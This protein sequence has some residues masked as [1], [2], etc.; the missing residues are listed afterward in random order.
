[1]CLRARAIW[2]GGEEVQRRCVCVYGVSGSFRLL[3]LERW[4]I[5]GVRRRAT[6]N[7]DAV[8]NVCVCVFKGNITWTRDNVT[9]IM[10]RSVYSVYVRVLNIRITLITVVTQ[11]IKKIVLLKF[12]F[13]ITFLD[14]KINLKSLEFR[15]LN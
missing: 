14:F 9:K 7:D 1:M 13:K 12:I 10:E 2:T 8:S 11:C 6:A 3:L 15:A 4:A 5:Y